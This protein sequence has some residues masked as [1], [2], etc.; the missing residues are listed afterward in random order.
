MKK[1]ERAYLL[2]KD[3]LWNSFQIE[4]NH[5]DD[6]TT[7][8]ISIVDRGIREMMWE[9]YQSTIPQPEWF[10]AFNH[11]EF[12][13][14]LRSNLGFYNII[15]SCFAQTE[16]S[17]FY[18]IGPFRTEDANAKYFERII[19]ES[20]IPQEK[21][22]DAQAI[23]RALPTAPVSL[24]TNLSKR[25]LGEF[26]PVFLDLE[27][28]NKNFLNEVHT[29]SQSREELRY[30]AKI[31]EEYCAQLI[32]FLKQL[33]AGEIEQARISLNEYLNRYGFENSSNLAEL[34]RISQMLND[35]AALTLLHTN[36]HPRHV[37]RLQTQM[38]DSILSATDINSVKYIPYDICHKY[39]L[40]IKNYSHDGYSK[41]IREMLDYIDHHL[42]EELS[43]DV[44]STHFE[45]NPSALSAQFKKETSCTL[46]TYIKQARI[47]EAIKLINTTDQPFSEIA[48]EVGYE[49]FAY[50]SRV[51]KQITGISPRDYKKSL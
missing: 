5:F 23:F 34:K 13:L 17:Q 7:Q 42:D 24:I 11:R 39:Y 27:P 2:L 20:G 26:Y 29:P 48:M 37:L 30:L 4:C 25:I 15:F 19:M 41:I 50:F 36:V 6:V 45:R 1:A 22:L 9:D 40:L 51:F 14:V 16:Q 35:Y 32:L 47:Q 18:I 46:T 10:E 28:E 38:A 44:I 49:D 21:M 33:Q 43:L 31:S 3:V 12:I 8:N